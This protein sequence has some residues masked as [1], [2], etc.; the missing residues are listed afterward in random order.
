MYSML[1][2]LLEATGL[3]QQNYY[4]YIDSVQTL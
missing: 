2:L 3:Y 4:L 1:L